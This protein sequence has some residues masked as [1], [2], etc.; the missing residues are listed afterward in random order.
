MKTEL[1]AAKQKNEQPD[2]ESSFIKTQ[3]KSQLTQNVG[4]TI[5]AYS[6]DGL[7]A[8]QSTETKLASDNGNLQNNYPVSYQDNKE[9]PAG[10]YGGENYP[11]VKPIGQPF[12][13]ANQAYH[14]YKEPS[15][16]A[17]Q[18]IARMTEVLKAKLEQHPRL[19]SAIAKRG[20]VE[21]LENSTHI[22]SSQD[23]FWD[24]RGKESKFIQALSAAYTTIEKSQGKVSTQEADSVA[25]SLQKWTEDAQFLNRNYVD[26]IN[27]IQ[28]IYANTKKPLTENH[29]KTMDKDSKDAAVTK[30]VKNLV[31]R[32][33][34]TLVQ[35]NREDGSKLVQGK[36]YI[37]ESNQNTGLTRIT[38][39]STA[40]ILLSI[41]NNQVKA[42]NLNSDVYQ[43][44]KS[45]V[46]AVDE[47]IIAA[48]E[49]T[50]YNSSNPVNNVVNKNQVSK[51][52]NE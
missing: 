4:T 30:E 2:K 37:L 27:Q 40:D 22:S 8:A 16:Q 7:G 39:T 17:A 41:E 26:T 31:T 29:L 50:G 45:A 49:I 48:Q 1:V 34:N 24:G 19:V 38:S 32:L 18:K 36:R 20:G 46:Q 47:K 42:N 13:S 33:T 9:L 3:R 35:D 25:Q 21:F 51:K 28:N 23:K 14:A 6:N 15:E 43:S 12:V 5:S 10:N 11:D 52:I 44:L